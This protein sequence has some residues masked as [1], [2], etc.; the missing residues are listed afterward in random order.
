[1]TSWSDLFIFN[2]YANTLRQFPWPNEREGTVGQTGGDARPDAGG[3]DRQS[4]Y[5]T[6][7]QPTESK[8]TFLPSFALRGRHHRRTDERKATSAGTLAINLGGLTGR[9]GFEGKELAGANAK[10]NLFVLTAEEDRGAR[11]EICP[12]QERDGRGRDRGAIEGEWQARR[13]RNE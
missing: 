3:R 10:V 11:I 1:M 13:K 8:A 9:A 5:I 4:E 7:I 2:R 12:R 6:T